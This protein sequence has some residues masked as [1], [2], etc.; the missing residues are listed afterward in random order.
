MEL[1]VRAVG[2]SGITSDRAAAHNS[3]HG[4]SEPG[5]YWAVDVKVENSDSTALR[6]GSMARYWRTG[7]DAELDAAAINRGEK[8]YKSSGRR[9]VDPVITEAEAFWSSR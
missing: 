8:F 6:E 5:T 9:Y 7:A 3:V 2:R 4:I 1:R